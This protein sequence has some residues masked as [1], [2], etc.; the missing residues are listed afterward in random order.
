[1]V[2]LPERL[3]YNTRIPTY[4][5]VLTNRKEPSRAGNIIL[6]D[7]RQHFAAMR[8]SIA[9][10]SRYLTTEQISEIIAIRRSAT[11]TDTSA[12]DIAKIVPVADFR[13]E[14]LVGGVTR[15]GYEIRKARLPQRH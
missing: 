12:P 15:V 3:L 10:K 4:I 14:R 7:C 5:W 13:Y 9:D 2:A 11:A 1:M 8:R 6:M